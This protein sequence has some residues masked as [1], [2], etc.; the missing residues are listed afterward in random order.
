[1]KHRYSPL[2][3]ALAAVG[4][5]AQAQQAAGN[6][7]QKVSEVERIVVTGIPSGTAARKVDTSY[8]FTNMSEEIQLFRWKLGS[9]S[10]EGE[11]EIAG[12]SAL[13]KEK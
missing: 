8:A 3:L 12:R 1:M 5:S 4:F 10:L 11:E 9:Y 7:P 6:S 2:F 13:L